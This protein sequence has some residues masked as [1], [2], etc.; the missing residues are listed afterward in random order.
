MRLTKFMSRPILT[1]YN[2]GGYSALLV[3]RWTK[4]ESV[5]FFALVIELCTCESHFYQIATCAA[6]F[7]LWK[8]A[9]SFSDNLPFG[10]YIYRQTTRTVAVRT[11]ATVQ[12]N[13]IHQ[14]MILRLSV[15]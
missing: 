14:E 13:Q 10:R 15:A 5:I 3:P 11:T 1:E 8:A 7:R 4:W 2:T 6:L 12:Y 9:I